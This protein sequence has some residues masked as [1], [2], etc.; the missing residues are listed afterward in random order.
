M[1]KVEQQE[2]LQSAVVNLPWKWNKARPFELKDEAP[3]RT[4]R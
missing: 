3:D 1:E 2:C 4:A